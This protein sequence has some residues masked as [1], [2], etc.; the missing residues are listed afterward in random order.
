MLA[1]L[2]S[3]RPLY[4]PARESAS[5]PASKGVLVALWTERT[6]TLEMWGVILEASH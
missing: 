3:S 6:E 5:T 2:G 4:D 1:S